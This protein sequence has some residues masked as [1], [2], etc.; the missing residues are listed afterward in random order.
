M[1]QNDPPSEQ[2]LIDLLN[3]AYSLHQSGANAEAETLYLRLLPLLPD[4]WQ[5]L[6]NFGLLLHD[7]GRYDEAAEFYDRALLLGIEDGDLYFNLALTC[8]QR[9]LLDQAIIYYR[10]AIDL[11]PDDIDCLYNL[12]GCYLAGCRYEE[13]VTAYEAVL[14]R[15]PSHLPALNNLAYLTHISGKTEQARELYQL[16]LTIR[17]DSP[18]AEHMLAAL[19]GSPR[20][21]APPS[22]IR[23]IF[24]HYADHYESSLLTDLHYSV[25]ERL[26][27][28]VTSVADKNIFAGML[29][30]GCGTGLIGE[31]FSSHTK[32]LHGVDI[33]EKMLALARQKKCYDDL[34]VAEIEQFLSSC[35]SCYDLIVA[36][37]VFPYLGR[38]EHIFSCGRSVI[39]DDGLFF[40]TIEE[41]ID[42]DRSL[43]LG[44]SG[45][46]AHA[47][48]FVRTSAGECGWS[49]LC[50]QRIPLR[51]E[52]DTWVAGIVY[53][54]KKQQ[55]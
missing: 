51:K 24:N 38:L 4:C 19:S 44:P 12:A 47:D 37:D 7:S 20:T 14:R 5:L 28:L 54:L 45:R 23:D 16:V 22:Y 17:P 26:V 53:G 8:K 43:L 15:D 27:N 35:R 48:W 13:A 46:F 34:Y 36:A 55:P 52:R 29:D 32:L 9:G 49:I 40:F 10:K 21:S 33:S 50:A 25:P 30:L 3:E 1:Y 6:Y 18:S 2:Q 41:L 11:Q 42:D 31:H 39:T